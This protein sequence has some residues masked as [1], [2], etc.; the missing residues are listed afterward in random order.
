M[1]VTAPGQ[2]DPASLLAVFFFQAFV[3]TQPDS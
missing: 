1:Q 2:G 3:Y